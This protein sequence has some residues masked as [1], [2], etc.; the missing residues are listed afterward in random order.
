[1]QERPPCAP[2]PTA[3]PDARRRRSTTTAPAT[4][5]APTSCNTYR[6]VGGGSCAEACIGSLVGTCPIAVIALLGGLSEGRCAEVGFG[7]ANGTVAIPAGPCGNILY[8]V[9]APG[10]PTDTR[11]Q[12]RD[13]ALAELPQLVQQLSPAAQHIVKEPL[14]AIQESIGAHT[15]CELPM[16][17]GPSEPFACQSTTGAQKNAVMVTLGGETALILPQLAAAKAAGKRI[18]FCRSD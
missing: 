6:K 4:T 9:F 3:P 18:C 14:D 16:P 10:S 15:P 2:P 11:K 13:Q 8:N 7:T 12:K 5:S 17:P 1:M